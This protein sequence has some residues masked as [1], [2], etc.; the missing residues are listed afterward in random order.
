MT[1]QGLAKTRKIHYKLFNI[2]K[3]HLQD[4]LNKIRSFLPNRA[5]LDS[6]LNKDSAFLEDIVSR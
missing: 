2:N 4:E 6:I 1:E 5:L 3:P